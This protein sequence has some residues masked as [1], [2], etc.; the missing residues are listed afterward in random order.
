MSAAAAWCDGAFVAAVPRA[1]RG[2]FETMGAHAGELPLWSRHLARLARAAVQLGVAF[3]PPRDLEDAARDLLA[4]TGQRDG[5]LRLELGAMERAARWSMTTRARSSATGPVRLALVVAPRSAADPDAGFK[6]VA[7]APYDA[8]LER[9]RATGAEEALLVDAA[10]N[11]LEAAT[12]NVL[13]L[14]GN[15]LCTPPLDGRIVPGIARALLLEG[16][17]ARGTPAVERAVHRDELPRAQGV[18]IT[19]AVHGARVASLDG[20]AVD[21]VA[22]EPWTRRLDEIWAA[23]LGGV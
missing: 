7:R 1:E 11:L 20:S 23:A 10:G 4:R 16:L 21:A 3:V 13:V 15:A 18:W 9:A 6:S 2:A 12:A 22:A 19:N 8:A 14:M 17:A 5:I